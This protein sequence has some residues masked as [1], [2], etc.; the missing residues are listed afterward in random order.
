MKELVFILILQ[1]IGNSNPV[2]EI[3]KYTHM[4]ECQK[5]G[6]EALVNMKRLSNPNK[7]WKNPHYPDAFCIGVRR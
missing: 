3:G 5:A 6:K 4:E 2:L 1:F 7:K